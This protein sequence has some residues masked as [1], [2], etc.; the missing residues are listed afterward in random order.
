MRR[1]FTIVCKEKTE[2]VY[3]DSNLCASSFHA[4]YVFRRTLSSAASLA[5]G[6]SVE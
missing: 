6:S 4:K 5:Q 1:C 3:G 2:L